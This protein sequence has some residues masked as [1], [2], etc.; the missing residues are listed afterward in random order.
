MSNIT[1]KISVLRSEA[2]SEAK[3][4]VGV[5]GYTGTGGRGG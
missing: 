1:I 2:F 5:H 4:S 3:A